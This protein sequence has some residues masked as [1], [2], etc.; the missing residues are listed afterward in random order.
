LVSTALAGFLYVSQLS[1][2]QMVKQQSGSIVNLSTTLV[3]Q[4]I[5]GAP[6][7]IPSGYTDAAVAPAESA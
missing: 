1:V 3:D 7:A 6:A 2:K 5:T 4:P